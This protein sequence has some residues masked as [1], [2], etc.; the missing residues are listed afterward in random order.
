MKEKDL[1]ANQD[2]LN[3]LFSKILQLNNLMKSDIKELFEIE[4]TKNVFYK[5]TS[6]NFSLVNRS[7]ELNK[8]YITLFK[9]ENFISAIT[10]LRMQIE[11]CLRLYAFTIMDNMP[12]CLDNFIEG[13]EF[14]DLTGNN[15]KKLYDSYLAKEIDKNIPNYEFYNMYKKYCEVIHFSG[16]YQGLNNKLESLKSG[17]SI[18]LFLGGG[19]KMPHFN[20]Y[21]KIIYTKS[22]FYS[23]KIIFGLFREY[24]TEMTKMRC[25]RQN[26]CT[27]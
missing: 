10:I 8:G 16:F 19:N 9:S 3:L 13:V 20:L 5:L 4:T 23:S 15:G 11:N 6:I 18:T 14:K 24:K 7:I 1:P 12:E 17:H 25:N 27:F 22:I 21:N 2:T 26:G